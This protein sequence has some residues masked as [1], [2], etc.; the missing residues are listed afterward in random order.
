MPVLVFQFQP[1]LFLSPSNQLL[2][3]PRMETRAVYRRLCAFTLSP[4]II[5]I[6]LTSSQ[7]ADCA[8]ELFAMR[9][10]TFRLKNP[11]RRIPGGLGHVNYCS[12]SSAGEGVG[13]CC[14]LV[15]YK[16]KIGPIR[17]NF[18]MG[19][20]TANAKFCLLLTMKIQISHFKNCKK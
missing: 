13:L 3:C 20:M 11:S 10:K 7:L 19:F 9:N 14:A 4:I 16:F 12:Y 6:I 17:G 2:P 15:F 1:T 18:C 5:P 8:T